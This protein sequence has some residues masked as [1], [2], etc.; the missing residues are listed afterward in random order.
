MIDNKFWEKLIQ[1]LLTINPE[2]VI[3]SDYEVCK[4]D[5]IIGTITDDWVKRLWGLV[6]QLQLE[7][8]ENIKSAPEKIQQT[9]FFIRLSQGYFWE[10]VYALF[11]RAEDLEIDK[12]LEIIICTGWVIVASK[13]DIH[14]PSG[15]SKKYMNSN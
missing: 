13:P 7:L 6:P 5:I 15:W 10:F 12:D 11:P 3:S 8:E 2:E 1:K 9:E 4:G 14:R